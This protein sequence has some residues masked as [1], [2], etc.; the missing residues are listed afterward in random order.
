MAHD[1]ARLRHVEESMGTVFSFDIRGVRDE[2]RVRAGLHAAVASLHRADELFS[3]FRPDSQILRLGRGELALS[4]CAREV[5]EVLELCAAAERESAG[6]FTSRYAGGLDPTGLVKGWA[7]ER[8]VRMIASSGA[9]SVC[10]NGGGDIQLLGGPWRVGI[11][12]PLRPGGLATVI[13]SGEGLGVATSGPA[14]RGCH[15]IDPYTGRPPVG[16]LASVTVVCPEGLTT[17]DTRATAAY[18]MGERARGWLEALPGAEGFAV[19]PDG[20][21]WTTSGFHRYVAKVSA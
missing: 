12:D 17:A 20:R 21:T 9:G 11:S 19:M 1:T 4:A 15:V 2:P 13:E 8:A 18:A 3:A 7:V 10:L 14:E 6:W 16:G 5:V